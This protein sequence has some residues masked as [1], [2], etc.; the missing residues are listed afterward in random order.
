MYISKL[1][2]WV[3]W[4]TCVG[5]APLESFAF[6]S[7]STGADGA[8]NPT[9]NTEVQV[10]P[11]GVFNFTSVDI[12]N[13][14]TVTFRSN[15]T[16]TP[17]VMLVQG[18][19]N[20]AGT[21]QLNGAASPSTG[22]SGDGN[23]TD[24]GD[25]GRGGPGGFDGGRGGQAPRGSAGR[26]L[27]PGGGEGGHYVPDST[28]G[29]VTCTYGLGAGGGYASVGGSVTSGGGGY[30]PEA[31]A[32]GGS[33]YGVSTVLPLI[34]GSGGG[35]GTGGPSFAGSGGGGGGGA[36]LIAASGAVTLSGVI[37]ADGANA[38]DDD[39]GQNNG[40]AGGGGSGGAVRIIASR[41]Q[42]AG[43]V[44]ARGGQGGVS[45][46]WGMY[47]QTASRGGAGS[48]GRVR[49]EAEVFTFTGSTTPHYDVVATPA[50]AF[51]PNLPGLR[52]VA[53]G[54]FPVPQQPVGRADVTLPFGTP[55]PVAVE[56]ET[57][58]I[59]V[60][61]VVQVRVVPEF[62]GATSVDSSP[63]A[64]T[65]DSA[66]TSV[67]L[68]IPDGASVIEAEATFTVTADLGVRLAPYALNEPLDRVRVTATLGQ[69]STM[70]LQTASG[71]E[72]E[73]PAAALAAG[74]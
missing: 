20:V 47:S 43:K 44:F 50:P 68:D 48:P 69:P 54:G 74:W 9:V 26:G 27:G 56:V 66:S 63:T 22:H 8:F 15:A 13:G 11:S 60:S 38:G 37:L 35:G 52:I 41:L 67:D 25:P 46:N 18:D 24:D 19:A 34:G 31:I 59:P 53:V 14:I 4:A 32:V 39:T 36:L 62:G 65:L 21:V 55:N 70:I 33:T 17:V 71:R 23:I 61:S 10:P 1:V 57:Q 12:P 64:G 6:N 5:L 72:V 58:G 51:V 3:I 45:E 7:G 16:N 28:W 42:G 29:G 73:V 2:R 30:F 40:A 49:L